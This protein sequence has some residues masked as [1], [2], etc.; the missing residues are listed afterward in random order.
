[1]YNVMVKK[2][3]DA[4]A[5]GSSG[6]T[7]LSET[8]KVIEWVESQTWA[9]NTKKAAFIAFKSSLRDSQDPTLKGAEEA[10]TARMN[11]YRDRHNEI[12]ARQLLSPREKELFVTWPTILDA[13][14]KFRQGCATFWDI[15]DYVIYCLYTMVPPIRLDYSPLRVVSN[16][17]EAADISGNCLV[18]DASGYY[19]LLREYKT[20]HTL[21]ELKLEVGEELKKVLMMWLELNPSGWLLGTRDGEPMKETH[22][23]QQIRVIMKKAVG[24]SLGVNLLR[25][26][27]I[28][29]QRRG[30]KSLIEQNE[31]A[32]R[33]GHSVLMSQL[34]AR[35]DGM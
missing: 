24:K 35:L 23:G 8:A 1:M 18:A 10:Y 27:Y 3:R 5:P 31:M 4:V 13:R 7:F 6:L 29:Y 26:S 34:Y 11:F 17:T 33:M 14:E 12:A 32:R 2:A 21:G 19:F 30:E 9:I 22:L 20:A 16:G 15:Q 28:T 25:H